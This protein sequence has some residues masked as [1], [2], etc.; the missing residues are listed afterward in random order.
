MK[1]KLK[2]FTAFSKSILPN[3]AKYLEERYQFTDTEKRSII[4]LVITNALSQNK[5]KDFDDT[6]DKR[7]YSYIK[8]WIEKKLA[9]IDVDATIGWI[10]SLNKKILTD[11]IASNEEKEFLHNHKNII[12]QTLGKNILKADTA[13]V[14]SIFKFNELI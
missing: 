3:E 6:I 2:K 11:A 4:S 7:K 10:M 14:A 13:I 1:T 12:P 8:D 9:T 5:R